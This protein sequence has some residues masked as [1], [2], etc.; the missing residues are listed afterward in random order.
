[1]KIS[2][3]YTVQGDEVIEVSIL[4]KEIKDQ[5]R[6]IKK[7][8]ALAGKDILEEIEKIPMIKRLIMRYIARL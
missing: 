6:V 2:L 1:M 5:D 7:L 3:S 4:L 8:Q